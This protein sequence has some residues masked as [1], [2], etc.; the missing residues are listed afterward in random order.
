MS[1]SLDGIYGKRETNRGLPTY[2][3]DFEVREIMSLSEVIDY[4]SSP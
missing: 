1:F 4:D 3:Y 2:F